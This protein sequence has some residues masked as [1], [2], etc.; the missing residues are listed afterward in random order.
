MRSATHSPSEKRLRAFFKNF[1]TSLFFRS[2]ALDASVP[3]IEDRPFK[4][5]S[6]QFL[7][8]AMASSPGAAP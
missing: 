4:T 1:I 3:F 5:A 2:A 8:S 7:K 6:A